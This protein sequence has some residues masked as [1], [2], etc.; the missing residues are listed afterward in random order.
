[1]NRISGTKEHLCNKKAIHFTE[2]L[3]LITTTVADIV[4]K[5]TLCQSVSGWQIKASSPKQSLSMG[6]YEH[7]RVGKW[8]QKLQQKKSFFWN[9]CW[10]GTQRILALQQCVLRNGQCVSADLMQFDIRWQKFAK[11]DMQQIGQSDAQHSI[12]H[13]RLTNEVNANLH[14]NQTNVTGASAHLE[15]RVPN[16]NK[17]IVDRNWTGNFLIKKSSSGS[18]EKQ[19]LTQTTI[20][21][22]N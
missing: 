16:W 5:L 20:T 13:H 19:R 3:E 9:H 6:T 7:W 4:S 2:D 15:M 17:S 8:N 22:P 21:Q 11:I 14:S 12:T 1:M 10:F 18:A